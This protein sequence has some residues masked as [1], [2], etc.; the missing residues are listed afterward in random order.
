MA[1]QPEPAEDENDPIFRRAVRLPGIGATSRK[2]KERVRPRKKK[3]VAGTKRRMER[4]VF[5]KGE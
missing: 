3:A 1:A 4:L 2:R 5:G